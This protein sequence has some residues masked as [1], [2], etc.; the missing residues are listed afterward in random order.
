M[1]YVALVEQLDLSHW[2]IIG[3]VAFV[4]F[5]VVGIV[6]R[7]AEARFMWRWLR[8]SFWRALDQ[9]MPDDRPI[10]LTG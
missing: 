2:L 6:V 4:L 10:F 5:G 3:G 7:R 9:L 8:S 1:E